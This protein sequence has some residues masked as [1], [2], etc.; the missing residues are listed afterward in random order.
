MSVQKGAKIISIH[1]TAR[2][3]WFLFLVKRLV[4]ATC[5]S[6]MPPPISSAAVSNVPT[7]AF[8]VTAVIEQNRGE[9]VAVKL[10]ESEIFPERNYFAKRRPMM[11]IVAIL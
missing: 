2:Y 1:Q 6:C 3:L 5:K 9:E 8:S 4:L 11:W 10:T 7:M